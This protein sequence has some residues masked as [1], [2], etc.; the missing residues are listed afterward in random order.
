MISSNKAKGFTLVELLIVIVVIGILAAISI[1]AYNG[2]TQK[3]RDDQRISDVRNITSAAAAY[4]AENGKW[5]TVAELKAFNTVKL[6]GTAA[7]RLD[8][9][10]SL[11]ISASNKDDKYKYEFCTTAGSGGGAAANTGVKVTYWKEDGNKLDTLST[12]TGTGC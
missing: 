5:P 11:T 9:G 4:N 6:S 1:V 12:G 10:A 7:S 8:D 3:S 2:V